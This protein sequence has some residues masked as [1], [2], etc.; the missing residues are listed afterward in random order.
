MKIYALVMAVSIAVPLALSFEPKI[1]FYRKFYALFPALLITGLLFLCWDVVA[2]ERGDW[3]FDTRF[4]LGPRLWGI[5]VEEVLFFL[6]IPYCCLFIYEV[7]CHFHRDRI[8]PIPSWFFAMVVVVLICLASV[9]RKQEYTFTVL[10]ISALSV[11]VTS[12]IAP[13]ILRSRNYWIFLAITYVPFMLINSLLTSIP[14]VIY[15]PRAIWGLRIATVPVEDFFYSYAL[16]SINF[17]IYQFARSVSR[18]QRHM[19]KLA[20][21]LSEMKTML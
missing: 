17:A 21:E 14:V 11:T 12:V 15:N 2:V 16:L 19:R 13:V 10:A 5:P 4:L 9:F 1:K 6:I 20:R 8:W 3:R 7:V 18:R